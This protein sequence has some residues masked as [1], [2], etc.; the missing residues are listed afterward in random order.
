MTLIWMFDITVFVMVFCVIMFLRRYQLGMVVLLLV[1]LLL[2][3]G[4]MLIRGDVDCCSVPVV[5]YALSLPLLVVKENRRN[6]VFV[7]RHNPY[8]ENN[9]LPKVL[10]VLLLC[11]GGLCSF[12]MLIFAILSRDTAIP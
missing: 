10:R 5:L 1:C 12:A 3:G 4:S 11:L 2:A 9:G 7:E 8:C 6:H